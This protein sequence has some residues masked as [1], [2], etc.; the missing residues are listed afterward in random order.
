LVQ[1]AE[2]IAKAHPHLSAHAGEIKGGNTEMA[3]AL[4][5]GIPAITLNGMGQEG[6]ELYW[7]MVEDTYDKMDSEVMGRA[8]EFV[9]E[10]IT[11]IDSM[12]Q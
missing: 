11:A 10:Y 1:L 6:E 4:R 5:A 7:H 9:W 2:Q 3:D 12:L 8:Y